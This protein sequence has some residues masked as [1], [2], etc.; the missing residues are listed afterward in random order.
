[1]TERFSQVMFV[2]EMISNS[3]RLEASHSLWF[4]FYYAKK[5]YVE[6]L[7][8]HFAVELIQT[9]TESQWGSTTVYTKGSYVY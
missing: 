2:E 6:I 3:C 5:N 9:S 7:T 8:L 1:M 4:N